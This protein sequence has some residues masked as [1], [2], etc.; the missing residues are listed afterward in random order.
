MACFLLKLD[1]FGNQDKVAIWFLNM[2]L[3]RIQNSGKILQMEQDLQGYRGITLKRVKII[4]SAL[5]MSGVYEF[6]RLKC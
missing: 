5:G 6:G 4:S 2:S 3:V 1:N